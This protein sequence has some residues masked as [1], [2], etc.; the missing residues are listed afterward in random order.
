[1]AYISVFKMANMKIEDFVRRMYSSIRSRS[2]RSGNPYPSFSKDELR[3]WLY[4]NNLQ[5]KWINYL[6]SN[7]N[8]DKRPSIDRLDDY[9]IY[10][11]SNMQLIT[12]KENNIKGVN[13][14]KHHTNCHNRQHRKS[15]MISSQTE[16]LF[17][18]SV[19]DCA[20]YLDVLVSSVSRVLSGK[21]K[22]IKKYKVE[23][24]NN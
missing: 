12:W 11:F 20:D 14:K 18:N 13:S 6:E 15:I 9:G 22:T 2:K 8:K 19:T 16:T 7:C 4:E 23:Y 17:F 1:M 10:E 21:R 5:S 24:N 3:N